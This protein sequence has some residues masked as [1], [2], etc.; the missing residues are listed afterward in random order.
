MLDKSETADQLVTEFIKIRDWL[1]AETKRFTDFC[2]PYREKQSLIESKLLEILNQQGANSLKTD[3]G[4]VYKSVIV[5]PQIADREKYL[6]AVLENYD[7]WGAG[8]LQR[9][10]PKKE[11]LD[12]YMAST[13][14]QLPDGVTTT[15]YVHCNV[16]KS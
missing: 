16:R 12:D 3:A 14:G 7:T 13:N 11:S 6:D 9:G 2:I 10:K 5:T 4:T 15:S 1:T 8:M